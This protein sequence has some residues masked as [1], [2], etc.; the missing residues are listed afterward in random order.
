MLT[1]IC[2]LIIF[3]RDLLKISKSFL[4]T[5]VFIKVL[6]LFCLFNFIEEFFLTILNV[7]TIT[8]L[9]LNIKNT[10]KKYFFIK[11][12]TIRYAIN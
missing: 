4:L 5:V 2:L 1:K 8:N 11:L 12:L 3:V 9:L 6:L 7:F 10:R